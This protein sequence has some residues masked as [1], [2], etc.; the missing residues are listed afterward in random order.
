VEADVWP[1]GDE[2]LVGHSR[3][4]VL[5]GTLHYLYLDPL[6]VM[7]EDHNTPSRKWPEV[8]KNG[9]AGVFANDPKQALTL[10]IDFKPDRDQIRHLLTK[11][12]QYLR[13]K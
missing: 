3:Y 11:R 10:S 1:W 7:L 2:L 4:T 8:E 12:L 13:E 5:R 6:L 9:L